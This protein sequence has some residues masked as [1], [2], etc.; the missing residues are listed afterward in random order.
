MIDLS[1]VMIT[2]NHEKYIAKAIQSVLGQR[3][4]Y[5]YELLIGDDHSKDGTVDE[6]STVL[7]DSKVEIHFYQREKNIG[8]VNNELDL[9]LRAKGRYIAILEGDDYWTD[10]CKLDKCL[11]WLEEHGSMCAVYHDCVVV[12]E[13]DRVYAEHFWDSVRREYSV[14]DYNNYCLP[15]QTGTIV[16]RNIMNRVDL[17]L[18]KDIRFLPGDRIMPLLFLRYGGIGYLKDRMSAYRCVT[19]EGEETWSS[20]HMLNPKERYFNMAKGTL[21]AEE[22]GRRLGVRV[23]LQEVRSLNAAISLVTGVR[24]RKKNYI[25]IF[26]EISK[27]SPNKLLFWIEQ[28]FFIPRCIIGHKKWI[29]LR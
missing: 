5:T 15:G 24:Y 20:Q 13:N 2:Y 22:L 23:H 4:K 14:R 21:E 9:L 7:H 27:L 6:I 3:T 16:F 28:I 17:K 29:Q 18:I 10:M 8:M 26:W 11:D 12:D 19:K 1:V 25:E